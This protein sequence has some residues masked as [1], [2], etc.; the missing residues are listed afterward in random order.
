[1]R[2]WTIPIGWFLLMPSH[3]ARGARPH[4]LRRLGRELVVFRDAEGAPVVADAFCPHLGADLGG[5]KVVDGTLRCPFHGFRFGVRGRC[6]HVPELDRIPERLALNVLPARECEG[7]LFAWF[8]PEGHAPAHE[9]A[10]AF[11][12]EDERAWS[13]PTFLTTEVETLAGPDVALSQ[14]TG[15][16]AAPFFVARHRSNRPVALETWSATFVTPIDRHRAAITFV[17]RFRRPSAFVAARS[18]MDELLRRHAP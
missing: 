13:A 15:R 6:V 1:M 2:S 9:P 3:R 16:A 7:A 11:S 18:A 5:G 8:H 14:L 12:D 10:R 4:R 17:L